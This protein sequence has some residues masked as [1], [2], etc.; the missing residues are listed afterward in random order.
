MTYSD[1][2]SADE[3]SESSISTTEFRRQAKA[4][5]EAR[6]TWS[7]VVSLYS[8]CSLSFPSDK[9]VALSG[10]ARFASHAMKSGYLAGLWGSD[11]VED[12]AWTAITPEET[13]YEESLKAPSWSW[14]SLNSDIDMNFDEKVLM[15][16]LA[17]VMDAKVTLADTNPFG[18]VV[19]GRLVLRGS[20]IILR[21]SPECANTAYD[22]RFWYTL[23]V[24]WDKADH[25]KKF[26]KFD[27]APDIYKTYIK[28]DLGPYDVFFLPIRHGI[29]FS[30]FDGI[31]LQPTGV[32]R[33]EFKR[34]GVGNF[35]IKSRLQM[36]WD[37]ID[38]IK[39]KHL[40][41]GFYIEEIEGTS[42]GDKTDMIVSIV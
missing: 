36:V 31:L 4:H 26:G 38:F 25:E 37:V 9:L 8:T 10:L 33:G 13:Q 12:L 39:I 34:V 32:E 42:R 30:R 29:L 20:L 21:L 14:V 41:Q 1:P 22:D 7:K 15:G 17:V 35:G 18:Q 24:K 19:S 16:T 28:T 27:G 5:T 11:L 6:R 23:E 40:Y 2:S 3:N